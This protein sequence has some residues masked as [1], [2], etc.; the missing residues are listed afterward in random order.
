MSVENV[1]DDQDGR[2]QVGA[3]LQAF[4]EARRLSVRKT[5][6]AAGVSPSFVSQLERGKSNASVAVLQK[7][8]DVLDIHV[9]DLFASTDPAV[10]PVRM[11]TREPLVTREGITKYLITPSSHSPLA[12]YDATFDPAANTGDP[13]SHAGLI[14]T[15]VV[16]HHEVTIQL[17]DDPYILKTGDSISYVSETPH[18]ISNHTSER[19]RIHWLCAPVLAAGDRN[20][21]ARDA[22]PRRS[23]DGSATLGKEQP[24]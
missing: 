20:E 13:Y 3:R 17:G 11:A 15:V 18:R 22:A 23:G 14:E 2:H 1:A 9:S 16:L 10:K 5:A 7:L 21:A 19:S 12:L 24:S 4:R 6:L 8:C